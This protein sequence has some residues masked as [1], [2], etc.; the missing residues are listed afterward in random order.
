M[1]PFHGVRPLRDHTTHG[2]PSHVS[3][4]IEHMN[5]PR[6]STRQNMVAKG[7]HA[8][9]SVG[10]HWAPLMRGTLLDVWLMHWRVLHCG[11]RGTRCMDRRI[12]QTRDDLRHA[13]TNL[14]YARMYPV[15]EQLEWL[16]TFFVAMC[17]GCGVCAV[18]GLPDM[19]DMSR[20]RCLQTEV[21]APQPCRRACPP[22]AVQSRRQRRAGYMPTVTV[23]V[24]VD[25]Y[26]CV[27]G[28]VRMC[29]CVRVCV[30]VCAYVW[31]SYATAL[32]IDS[33]NVHVPHVRLAACVTFPNSNI[34][35]TSVCGCVC[36]H[37]CHTTQDQNQIAYTLTTC[38][39]LCCA[40]TGVLM[41]PVRSGGLHP[42]AR[43]VQRCRR[44][45]RHRMCVALR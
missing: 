3:R 35:C 10:R 18:S 24:W 6:T 33:V 42:R 15:W 32:C 11:M 36:M 13:R 30:R 27:L 44:L 23:H 39:A 20:V 28:C 31:D 12:L 1:H 14:G 16:Y 37:P 29:A 17:A 2:V 5:V 43:S 25:V 19:N 8:A 22:T 7:A 9:A 4:C 40:G 21:R 26:V 45:Q 34:A 41:D 38:V